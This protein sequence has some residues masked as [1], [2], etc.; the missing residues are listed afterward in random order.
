MV[1][2]RGA[3]VNGLSTIGFPAGLAA[4]GF[5]LVSDGSA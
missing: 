3:F 1:G 4:A 2:W 5:D